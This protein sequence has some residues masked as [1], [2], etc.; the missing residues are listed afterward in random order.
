ML[1][2]RPSYSSTQ[3]QHIQ[4]YVLTNSRDERQDYVVE[5]E[6]AGYTHHGAHLK[7]PRKENVPLLNT[8]YK[9]GDLRHKTHTTNKLQKSN[10]QPHEHVSARLQRHG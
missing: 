5:Q 8:Q 4:Q 1:I 9:Q 2:R 7:G 10:R 3:R 6:R